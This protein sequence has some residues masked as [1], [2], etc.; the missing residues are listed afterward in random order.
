MRQYHLVALQ[1][2]ANRIVVKAA[3]VA[4]LADAQT[5]PFEFL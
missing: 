3:H 5:L 2:F 1:I 4:Y